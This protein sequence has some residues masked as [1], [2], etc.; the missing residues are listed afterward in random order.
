MTVISKIANKTNTP[1]AWLAWIPIANLY[2]L[3]QISKTKWW[4]MFVFLFLLI[5]ELGIPIFILTIVFWCW[6]IVKRMSFPSWYA[7]LIL[8]PLVNF[9]IMGIV[10]WKN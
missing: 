6:K 7:F 3:T 8:V 10:A 5:P 4:F 2:L 1:N 9:V